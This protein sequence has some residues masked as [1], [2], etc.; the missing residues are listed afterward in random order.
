MF[1]YLIQM[2]SNLTFNEKQ[3]K[4]TILKDLEY[5]NSIK[6]HNTFNDYKHWQTKYRSE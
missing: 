4:K 6:Y 1:V 5:I 3:I 2:K